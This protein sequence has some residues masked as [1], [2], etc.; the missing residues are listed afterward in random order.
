M[1]IVHVDYHAHGLRALGALMP[2]HNTI[3]ES[4]RR[5]LLRDVQQLLPPHERA[6]AVV[7]DEAK[8]MVFASATN[9]NVYYRRYP[10]ADTWRI[11]GAE[12]DVDACVPY[13]VRQARRQREAESDGE[14][15]T[16][17][18]HN[19]AHDTDG[20]HSASGNDS[21]SA[22]SASSTATSAEDV[23]EEA[24]ARFAEFYITHA[25][26]RP[27]PICY[28]GLRTGLSCSSHAVV[29]VYDRGRYYA[30]CAVHAYEFL[31]TSPT[32]ELRTEFP[33]WW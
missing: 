6:F 4:T 31:A 28:A 33:T 29:F 23:W 5:A 13:H 14:P 2:R 25:H 8:R 26:E 15:D 3:D 22:D 19:G 27:W 18:A 24:E 30:L 17:G 11:L 9:G 7:Y 21:A 12:S 16:D 32:A 10:A 20:A 1:R